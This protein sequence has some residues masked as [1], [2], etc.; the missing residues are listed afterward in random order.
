MA[1]W[2]KEDEIFTALVILLAALMLRPCGERF[3]DA[4]READLPRS[5][6]MELAEEWVFNEDDRR[7]FIR[8]HLDG[9]THERVAEESELSVQQTKARIRAVEKVL[10]QHL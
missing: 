1:Q 10:Q 6:W 4:F 8:K 7:M 2:V 5:A 9:L 3:R